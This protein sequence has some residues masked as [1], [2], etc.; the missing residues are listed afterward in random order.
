MFL[1]ALSVFERI[2]SGQLSFALTGPPQRVP[3]ANLLERLRGQLPF[4]DEGEFGALLEVWGCSR[5]AFCKAF[6]TADERLVAKTHLVPEWLLDVF[7]L[8]SESVPGNSINS[9]TTYGKV[10][11]S[12]FIHPVVVRSVRQLRTDLSLSCLRKDGPF[13]IESVAESLE[14]SLRIKLTAIIRRTL[15]LELRIASITGKLDGE[16]AADRFASFTRRLE[17]PQF[18]AYLWSEYPVLVRLLSR[19]AQNW[20]ASSLEFLIRLTD[21]WSALQETFPALRGQRL[22][23]VLPRGDSHKGQNVSLIKFTNGEQLV[24][25]PHSVDI[26][27]HFQEILVWLNGRRCVPPFRTLT[28]LGRKEYGWCEFVAS[29]SC[30]NRDQ[31]E[32]FYRRQGGYLALLYCL[33][34]TDIHWENVIA[35]GEHPVIVDL[36]TVFHPHIEPAGVSYGDAVTESVLHVGL[37]PRSIRRSKLPDVSGLGGKSGQST[38]YGLP[39]VE[40]EGTDEMQFS[41]KEV[42]LPGR[43]NRPSLNGVDVDARDFTTQILEGFTAVYRLLLHTGGELFKDKGVFANCRDDEIRVILRPTRLY[44]AMIIDS[45]HPDFCHSGLER[46]CLLLRRLWMSMPTQA[47]YLKKVLRAEFRDLYEGDVP[48]FRT[49]PTSRIVWGSDGSPIDGLLAE[50]SI[51]SVQQHILKLSESDLERQIYYI[52]ASLASTLISHGNPVEFRVN[53]PPAKANA[54]R[55]EFLEAA[56]EVGKK[57]ALLAHASENHVSWIGL[58]AVSGDGWE[59]GT[60]GLDLYNGLPGIA[61]FLAYLGLFCDDSS[62]TNLARCCA[63]SLWTSQ[64]NRHGLSDTGL[65]I[66]A[67][68]DRGGLVF[69]LIHLATVLKDKRMF[70]LIDEMLEVMP[71]W[72]AHDGRYD[73][74]G[75][76][77]GLI[78]A[79]LALCEVNNSRKALEVAVLAGRKTAENWRRTSNVGPLLAGYSHGAAGTA[80]M[81]FKLADHSGSNEY[82]VCALECLKYER[83]LFSE[84]HQNW[85]DLRGD[86]KGLRTGELSTQPLRFTTTWCHGAPGIGLA[87][88]ACLKY[89]DDE[90]MIGEIRTALDTTVKNGFYTTHCLCH[91]DLG[92]IEPLLVEQQSGYHLVDERQ[93][94]TKATGILQSLSRFGFLCGT[95]SRVPTPGLMVGLAGIGY[96]LLRLYDP[97]NTPSVL[98]LEPPHT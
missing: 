80:Y 16:T 63:N 41:L 26:D 15:V 27:S 59:F 69:A 58:S 98:L 31:I 23:A 88:L 6:S 72:I 21:D 90:H 73:I 17:D 91:G 89:W 46:D 51:D 81:L 22:A 9:R 19:T 67:F 57:L 45:L 25:K 87:R 29:E 44:T 11:F 20:V 74:L 82:R 37:L 32:D 33:H 1:E 60:V 12:D 49:T 7:E 54:S 2:E 52:Q 34:G 35:S 13:E 84:N 4:S 38:G 24:Y 36:E 53:P 77:A 18:R 76:P 55:T 10:D 71:E 86:L 56:K 30:G 62:F 66:G 48:V 96:G 93:V 50:S 64:K 65:Q 68:S 95:P 28:I 85:P 83:S 3:R 42:E 92:N 94:A 43:L 78:G 8:A 47:D 75:G 14:R 79:L 40:K 70:E 61:L 39:V 97:V 5:E